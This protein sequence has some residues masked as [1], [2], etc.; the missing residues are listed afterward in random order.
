M[1]QV[2]RTYLLLTA[3]VLLLSRAAGAQTID[4][5]VGFTGQSDLQLNGN[6]RT[7]GSAITL[8]DSTANGEHGS[9]RPHRR[10]SF[11]ALFTSAT[12]AVYAQSGNGRPHAAAGDR[13]HA[14]DA[15]S[16]FAARPASI[17]RGLTH[18][19]L[20]LAVLIGMGRVQ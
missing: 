16:A 11:A 13:I 2:T 10:L 4:H 7:S 3:A 12:G 15:R 6:A 9:L 8:T 5:S 17:W 1:T 18:S 14:L 20:V 19:S